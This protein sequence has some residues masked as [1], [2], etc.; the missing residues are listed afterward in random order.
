MARRGQGHR[1]MARL[2][3]AFAM[4]AVAKGILGDRYVLSLCLFELLGIPTYQLDPLQEGRASALSLVHFISSER[5]DSEL[6]VC[7]RTLMR[8]FDTTKASIRMRERKSK[9][10]R[11]VRSDWIKAQRPVEHR[12][13]LV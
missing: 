12:Y 9:G 13:R 1:H 10:F 11:F 3:Y 8:R 5:V 6:R 7:E 4:K 2:A